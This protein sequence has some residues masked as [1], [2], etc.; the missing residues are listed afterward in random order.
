MSTSSPKGEIYNYQAPWVIYA[1]NWSNRKPFRLAL[2]SFVED[3][4]N[5]I[6]IVD[7]DMERDSFRQVTQFG[8]SY[9]PTKLMWRPDAPMGTSD[10]I[11]TTGDFL[12]LWEVKD[13]DSVTEKFMFSTNVR[14]ST[15]R[16]L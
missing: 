15:A 8:H 4:S 10:L 6:Q 9:P 14:H 5:G 1:L 13:D 16:T 7:L 11:A 12:R 2:G 3:H